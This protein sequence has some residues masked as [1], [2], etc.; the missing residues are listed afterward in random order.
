V[1]G[2][3]HGAQTPAAARALQGLVESHPESAQ[4]GEITAYG[5]ALRLACQNRFHDRALIEAVVRTYPHALCVAHWALG[6]SVRLPYEVAAEI[7]CPDDPTVEYLMEDTIHVALAAAELALES[8]TFL[9]HD[10]AKMDVVGEL[11]GV[12][13]ESDVAIDGNRTDPPGA[14]LSPAVDEFR[15]SVLST[16]DS[17]IALPAG[18]V[19][20]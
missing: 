10:E 4:P 16:V 17:R 1:Y 11:P 18:T 3:L 5:T 14:D 13:E 15:R 2:L 12:P 7:R 19:R 20:A 9:P 6:S 8:L